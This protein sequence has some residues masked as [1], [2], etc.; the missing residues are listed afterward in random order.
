TGRVK[1]RST[2]TIT[3]L[4][5]LSLTTVPCSIRF[6]ITIS[7]LRLFGRALLGGDGL[8]ARDVAAHDAHAAG[9]L[10][11]SRCALEA[12]VEL[13]LLEL[14]QLVGKLV[15]RHRPDIACLHD[16]YS[17]MRCTKR[18][19]IGSLAAASDSASLAS[20]TDTPSRYN[21]MR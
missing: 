9:I 15:G 3:V 19:L 14:H 8:D 2:R 10:E 4:S 6:G 13:L 7:S 12:Q 20:S 1:R 5:C 11:L 16:L 21:R 18:V 17:T